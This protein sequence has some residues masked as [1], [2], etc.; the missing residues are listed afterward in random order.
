MS[1][2]R[3]GL[4]HALAHTVPAHDSYT[5]MWDEDQHST[6]ISATSMPTDVLSPP[7]IDIWFVHAV[8]HFTGGEASYGQTIALEIISAEWGVLWREE[9]TFIGQFSLA[10]TNDISFYIAPT[11]EIRVAFYNETDGYINDLGG[12]LTGACTFVMSVSNDEPP[13]PP[14]PP[15]IV[16]PGIARVPRVGTTQ[17]LFTR[18][19]P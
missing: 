8:A 11:D 7:W 18:T 2:Y 12:P 13:V 4:F 3:G 19:T 9:A 1:T 15:P 16:Y 14:P 5:F 17:D 10:T 6:N